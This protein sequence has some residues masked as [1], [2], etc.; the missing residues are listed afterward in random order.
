MITSLILFTVSILLT[1]SYQDYCQST[2]GNGTWRNDAPLAYET[3]FQD[4]ASQNVEGMIKFHNYLMEFLIIIGCAVVWIL[5]KAIKNP[6]NNYKTYKKFTHARDLEIGWTIL[7][8]VLLSAIGIPSFVLLYSLDAVTKTTMVIKI[9]GHQWFWSYEYPKTSLNVPAYGFDSYIVDV[10]GDQQEKTPEG[11]LR[12]L[13]TTS[14]AA[15]PV[16]SHIKLLI[17]SSDVLHSWAVPSFGVKVDACPGRLSKAALYV[18]R[19]GTFFGQCSEICGVNHG[20]MPITVNAVHAEELA[21]SLLLVN[22]TD[23][24][25]FELAD[26]ALKNLSNKENL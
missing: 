14:C 15:I 5:Y 12:L 1:L 7:P 9:I 25:T 8:A 23:L 22:E 16:K 13:K 26:V 4:P 6:A 2:P 11:A 18:K 24:P 17:T 21:V 20:F 19:C 3:Y 10:I